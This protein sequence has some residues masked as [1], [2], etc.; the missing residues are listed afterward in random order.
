MK[1]FTNGLSG[2]LTAVCLLLLFTAGQLRAQTVQTPTIIPASPTAQTF[3]RYG[4]IPVDY[5][6]GVPSIE[7]PIFTVEGR[8]LKVPISISYHASGVKVNDIASEVGL[9]W[10]LNAG[11]LVSRT[12]NGRR[13]EVAGTRTYFSASQLL[14]A[15]NSVANTYSAGC[16]QG[17]RDFEYFLTQQFAN[18]EDPISDRYFYKL[19]NGPSGVFTYSYT[20]VSESNAITLPYRPFKIE[21][22]INSSN[23]TFTRI[24][25]FKITDDKGIV[26]TFQTY[27]ANPTQDYS[28][29]FLKEMVSADGTDV[30]SFNYIGQTGGS[31]IPTES[32]LYQGWAE[33][34][35][36]NCTPQNLSSSLLEFGGAAP[37]FNTPVLESIVSS[38]AIVKF[39]YTNRNDFN[40][41]K[42]LNKITIAAANSPT[43]IIRQVTFTPKYFGTTDAN[44]RLGLDK[45]TIDAPGAQPQVY[46]F[47]YESQVLPDYPTKMA[48][49]TYSED[50]WGY[51]NGSNSAG[52]I[53][54]DFI[55]NTY[56][57]NYY[58]GNKD[59]DESY[60][61]KA[62]MLK[63]IKY[64]TGGKTVFSFQRHYSATAYPYRANPYDQDGYIGGFRVASITNYSA[65]NT[66]ANV[67]TYEYELPVIRQINAT[68]FNY[69]Q[70]FLEKREVLGG[71]GV[72]DSW[73]WANYSREM[74]SGNPVL[75]I[76][77]APGMPIMYQKVTEYNGTST[78]NQ[79]KTVYTYNAPYSPSDYLNNPE[80]PL[81]FEAPQFYHPYHYDKGNYLPELVSKTIY[82]FDGTNYH[83][84]SKDV[85]TYTPLFDSSFITGIKVS[86][87]RV[88][89]NIDVFCFSCPFDAITCASMLSQEIQTYLQSVVAIDTK[90]YQEASMLTNSKNYVYDPLDDTKYV[91]TSTDYTYKQ[92]NLSILERSTIS[93]KADALKTIYKYPDDFAGTAV[94]DAMVQRNIIT[95]SIEELSYK[96]NVF[97]KSTK[98]SYNFWSGTAWTTSG[99]Q[100]LPQSVATKSLNQNDYE[101]RLRFQAYDNKD[102]VLSVS[103]END[104]KQLY[105]W[106][107]NQNFPVAQV[108]N[109]SL[110]DVAYTSFEADSKGGW[111]FSG[112][113]IA[114]SS[115]PTGSKAYRPTTGNEI[116]KTG[117]SPN[118]TY[119]ISFWMRDGSISVTGAAGG[120]TNITRNG[121]QLYTYETA[122]STSVIVSGS[123]YI[124]ELRLYPKG[125]LMTTY[126]YLPL[127][128]VTAQSDASN[129]T[130]YYEYDILGRLSLVRDQDRNIIRKI[131]YNYAG[132]VE[133]CSTGN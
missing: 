34:T 66:I 19:P 123:A 92:S 51:Y 1:D 87:P 59:A 57:K 8:Q 120:A 86:R 22:T 72:P 133:D 40:Y 55:S 131:C 84:V 31:S 56:D 3:M 37:I 115:A 100:I 88:Y 94:Y 112:S 73:C 81:E 95:S 71:P 30:I 109:A 32:H 65:G 4:E 93:S 60:F 39:E 35:S 107:Y 62:C 16:L 76:E 15:L 77:V 42:R 90:A 12:I 18:Q 9:A 70:I 2:K 45:V 101:T 74:V 125:S 13:D 47:A 20:D 21:K 105:I 58:G 127:I 28:E 129:R 98:T 128:G 91:L 14:S 114:H 49:P 97:L 116:S 132:Q 119:V 80:H 110:S 83:P 5:S 54:V 46:E 106:D 69:D 10:A 25:Q 26:Y 68:Y 61:S 6:T 75:P 111:T 38:K 113:A 99:S 43:T 117:L 17:I 108:M 23:V 103:K 52:P 29:W 27:L 102:N 48:L 41:L 104:Q 130:T 7:I 126:T 53:P 36:T 64:P 24:S 89:P 67:K 63:E 11:G 79:G 122:G 82:S 121:W 78:N 118:I 124:D 85:N 96:N 50:Y 44:R 33:G